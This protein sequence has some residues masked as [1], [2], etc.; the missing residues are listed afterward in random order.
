MER[1]TS[2]KVGSRLRQAPT[3]G[4]GRAAEN[5]Y[6]SDAVF[7]L[8]TRAPRRLP[9]PSR[10]T[11]SLRKVLRDLADRVGEAAD[12]D[13]LAR[14]LTRDLPRALRLPAAVLMVWDR[15]L[16]RFQTVTPG[17][18]RMHPVAGEDAAAPPP[19]P[20]WL[21]SEGLLLETPGSNADAALLPLRAR[22]GLVGTLLLSLRSRRRREPFQPSEA[23][24]LWRLACRSALAVENHLYLAELVAVERVAA[25]GTMAGMLAHDFR[26]PMTVIRGYAELLA[27]GETSPE[28]VKQRAAT[29]VQ[30]VDRLDRMTAETLDFARGSGRLARRPLPIAAL[31]AEMARSLEV[32][33]PGLTLAAELRLDAEARVELDADKLRRAVGNIAANARDAMG[34][35]GTL[36]LRAALVPAADG[37]DTRLVIDL[38]DEGPGVAAEIRDRLFEPF[39]TRGKKGG[40]G[41]GLAVSKRFVEEH[42]G[43]LEL[44]PEGPGARFRLSLPVRGPEGAV[45]SKEGPSSPRE[46][47]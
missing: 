27:E 45:E 33:L 7:A 34:G 23:R 9:T 46:Q 12:L 41:L 13:A 24:L 20:R 38:A 14:L 42:G 37:A 21:V 35:R 26:G 31:L 8:S 10:R 15:K 47:P 40:T 1:A 32:E 6:H 25:L 44:L 36:H 16:E 28:D 3:G 4:V 39:V 22:T 5:R 30:M 2:L 29:I 18:P 43:T 19:Q 11:S 17:D